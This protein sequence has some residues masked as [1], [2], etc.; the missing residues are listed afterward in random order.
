MFGI[1]AYNTILTNR[2]Y[3]E[4]AREERE[5]YRR[6]QIQL[7]GLLRLNVVLELAQAHFPPA[8][9][10]PAGHSVSLLLACCVNHQGYR[11]ASWADSRTLS[12]RNQ[13][14]PK[15]HVKHLTLRQ[16]RAHN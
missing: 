10:S 2:L 9:W 7:R 13:E 11:Q 4:R 1:A 6:L 5:E 12:I 3:R 8:G 16:G 14:P 15:F